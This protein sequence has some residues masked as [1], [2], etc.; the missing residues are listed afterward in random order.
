MLSVPPATT[1]R[2]SPHWIAWAASIT[3]FMPDPQTLLTVVA[4]IEEG[5]PAPMATCRATFCPSP[6]PTTLPMITSSTWSGGKPARWTAS[7]TTTLPRAGAGTSASEPKKPPM[8]VR[9]APASQIS[10]FMI[11]YLRIVYMYMPPL[12]GITCPVT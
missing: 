11:A 2:A 10:L 12:T 6:A 7:L 4:P 5:S 1:A 9:A 3:A 8:G